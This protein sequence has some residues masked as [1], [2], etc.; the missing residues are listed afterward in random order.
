MQ[1]SMAI[2]PDSQEYAPDYGK[3]VDLVPAGNIVQVLE[4]QLKETLALLAEIPESRAG[5]RYAEG[6]WSIKEVLGHVIDCERI[7]AYRAL[8][9]GRNDSIAIEGFEQDDYVATGGFDNRTLADLTRELE[10]VRRATIDLLAGFPEEAW[11]RTGLASENRVSVRALAFI[12]AGHERHHRDVLR[13][14][15]L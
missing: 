14:R 13:S 3:Y 4:E 12:I 10:H 1:S 8:R 15:Y 2:K 7:F 5:Y 9:F 6:K 11:H